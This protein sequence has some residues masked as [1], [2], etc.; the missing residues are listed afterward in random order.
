MHW[1]TTL[2]DKQFFPGKGFFANR[3]MMALLLATDEVHAQPVLVK[4]VC[5]ENRFFA[6]LIIFKYEDTKDLAM[7]NGA[8][9]PP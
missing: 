3:S 9:M 4:H 6:I 7:I 2:T 1:C 5:L 8:A